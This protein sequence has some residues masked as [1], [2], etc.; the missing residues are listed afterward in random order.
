MPL[1][2]SKCLSSSSFILNYFQAS[3]GKQDWHPSPHVYS[4]LWLRLM[5]PQAIELVECLAL[6]QS[7]VTFPVST[8]MKWNSLAAFG[9]KNI[10]QRT[11]TGQNLAPKGGKRE[12][13]CLLLKVSQ[14]W[15]GEKHQVSGKAIRIPL[16]LSSTC[17]IVKTNK[18]WPWNVFEESS[19]PCVNHLISHFRAWTYWQ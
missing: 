13:G 17:L 14:R 18:I 16:S 4:S 6:L 10:S 1:I 9:G 8:A 3:F 5:V 2:L 19:C 12:G 7:Q 11:S 15:H